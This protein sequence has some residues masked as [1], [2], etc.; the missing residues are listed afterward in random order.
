MVKASN[1]TTYL[2]QEKKSQGTTT[3]AGRKPTATVVR[4]SGPALAAVICF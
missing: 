3:T 4:A 1:G 2:V